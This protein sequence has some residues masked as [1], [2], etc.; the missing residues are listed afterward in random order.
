M[1]VYEF[2]CPCGNTEEGLV[3]MGT[4]SI[5]CINCGKDM[6]KVISCSS[7]VLKGSGWAFD[8]YGSTKT[9]KKNK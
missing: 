8:N 9:K 7:F 2:E 3:S 6:K 5:K 4:N 1:P